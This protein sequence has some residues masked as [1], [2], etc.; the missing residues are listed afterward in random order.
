MDDSLSAD[1][2]MTGQRPV[3]AAEE[4]TEEETVDISSSVVICCYTTNRLGWLVEA[5]DSLT[6]Q[7]RRPEQTIVV[8]DKR[9]GL[10]EALRQGL[11]ESV[12]IIPNEASRGLSLARN[13]GLSAATGD[14]T[15]FLDDDVVADSDWLEHLLS[16]FSDPSVVGA[17]GRAVPD[18]VGSGKRPGWFPE[19]L[20]W[21]LGCT[22][23]SFG[24]KTTIV[25]NVFGC[26]M[27]FRRCRLLQ[28]NGF[29]PR[30]GG[31]ISGDDTDI[32][33][34]ASGND[35]RNHI[36]YEPKAVVRHK[37]PQQRQTYRHIAY[38]AWIQGVGKAITRSIHKRDGRVLSRE[39]SYLRL[40]VL[41]FFP[42]QL[43]RAFRH[44]RSSLGRI[45]AVTTVMLSIASGYALT[46]LGIHRV[47]LDRYKTT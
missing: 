38:N 17:G 10:E 27:A 11:P 5:V 20:D 6:R 9:E 16:V 46:R 39:K 21:T 45:A 31:P 44:P 2:K 24:D 40:L 13:T 41:G 36:V 19:E 22:D 4:R 37:V 14:V 23:A 7:T 43:L 29:D 15:V 33:L 25:R 42:R 34:R 26:N 3:S 8:F 35:G 28:I 47:N 1:G 18:W 30:L 32:C 12:M